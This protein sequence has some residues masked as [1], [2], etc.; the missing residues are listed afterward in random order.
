MEEEKANLKVIVD[1]DWSPDQIKNLTLAIVKFPAGTVQRW[2]VIADF[3]GKNQKET[4][5]KAK[6][7][8][9]K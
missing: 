4:I 1:K 2:K 5:A 7:I 6:E 8:H 3:V 9:D